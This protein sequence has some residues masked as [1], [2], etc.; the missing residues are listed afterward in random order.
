M[1]NS[2]SQFL[3]QIAWM[4]PQL[5]VDMLAVLMGF[6]YIQRWHRPALMAIGAGS[7]LLVAHVGGLIARTVI[8][9]SG[10]LSSGGGAMTA[11][12]IVN[13]VVAGISLAGYATL[14]FAIFTDRQPSGPPG[15]AYGGPPYGAPPHS[16][17]NPG[18]SASPFGGPPR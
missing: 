6:I 10:N 14:I 4:L 1:F 3:L 8:L 5:A 16:P 18:A 15:G 17:A 11:F 13:I 12:T 9:Q 7:V 2:P